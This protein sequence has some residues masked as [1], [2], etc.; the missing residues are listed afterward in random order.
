MKRRGRVIGIVAI[1]VQSV[2]LGIATNALRSDSLDYVRKPVTESRD[3]ADVRELFSGGDAKTQSPVE[4]SDT[5]PEHDQEEVQASD[6]A[7]QPRPDNTSE[8]TEKPVEPEKPDKKPERP[9]KPAEEKP[10]QTTNEDQAEEDKPVAQALFTTIDDAKS[11]YDAKTAVFADARFAAD[12]ATSHIPGAVSVPF[13]TTDKVPQ[14]FIDKCPKDKVI[15]TYCSDIECGA[16]TKLA[17]ALAAEG[18]ENVFILIEGLPGWTQK[19]YPV[20]EAGE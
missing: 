4:T 15:V 1:V 8:K 11:L 12:Y 19:G 5:R 10:T 17:D 7:G 9:K 18:Y 14:W 20:K 2:I 3:Y 13:E 6:T 16:A